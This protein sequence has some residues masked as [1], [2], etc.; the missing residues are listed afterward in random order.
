M[1]TSCKRRQPTAWSDFGMQ[2]RGNGKGNGLLEEAADLLVGL[3][4]ARAQLATEL[5]AD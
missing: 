5:A 3:S 2:Q 1:T 4:D